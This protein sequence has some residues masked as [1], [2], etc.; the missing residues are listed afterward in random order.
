[1]KQPNKIALVTGGAKR[2]G[3][4]LCQTLHQN[5][6]DIILHYRHS[7]E[8]ALSLQSELNSLRAN[9]CQ[10]IQADLSQLDAIQALRQTIK[11]QD[12]KIELLINNASAFFTNQIG[13][14]HE[15]DWDSLFNSNNKAIY[16]LTQAL[17]PF[18]SSSSSSSSSLSP[19]IIN[20]LD[21]YSEKPLKNFSLYSA[22]KAASNMLT[23]AMALE[24][25][26]QIRVNGVS[27]GAILWPEN[28]DGFESEESFIKKIPM[29]QLGK[30]EDIAQAVL[31]LHTMPYVTGQILAV[32]G[33]LSLN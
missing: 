26:P 18:L 23:K 33:G 13:S 2:I 19:S 16:F 25:A 7:H 24:L 32:D 4:S 31:A 12:L 15:S 14:S 1:M 17:I 20:I 30:P 22:S 21:I 27:P 3:A 10:I 9:S 28:E 8:A 6:F 29:Q 11:Q 5:G